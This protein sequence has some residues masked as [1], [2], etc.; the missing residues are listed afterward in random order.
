MKTLQNMLGG[1]GDAEA[2]HSRD[3]MLLPFLPPSSHALLRSMCSLA[4]PL[5]GAW[6]TAIPCHKASCL[7]PQA[8]L[9]QPKAMDRFGDHALLTEDRLAGQ[10]G[11]AVGAEGEVVLQQWHALAHPCPLQAYQHTAAGA[12]TSSFTT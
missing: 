1:T 3:R 8:S 5:A 11:Q 6:L 4:G 9:P 10:T 7:P 2:A 12:S